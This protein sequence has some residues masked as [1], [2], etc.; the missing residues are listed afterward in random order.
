MTKKRDGVSPSELSEL[1]VCPGQR[2]NFKKGMEICPNKDKCPFYVKDFYNYDF[3]PDQ[4][5]RFR[6]KKDFIKC[7]RWKAN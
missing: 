2:Y 3:R 7:D 6:F 5:I 4:I 1:L